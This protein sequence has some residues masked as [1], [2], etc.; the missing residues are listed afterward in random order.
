[1]GVVKFLEMSTTFWTIADWLVY[2]MCIITVQKYEE[3]NMLNCHNFLNSLSCKSC[4]VSNKWFI[5]GENIVNIYDFFVFFFIKP[6]EFG[7]NVSMVFLVSSRGY[8]KNT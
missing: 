8:R 1:M 4:V 6:V 7:E 5:G 2:F 3:I